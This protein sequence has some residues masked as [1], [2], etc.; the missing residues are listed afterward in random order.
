MTMPGPIDAEL[1]AQRRERHRRGQIE[2]DIGMLCLFGQLAASL[3]AG[4]WAVAEIEDS[5]GEL[6]VYAAV[7]FLFAL[8]AAHT[9]ANAA[10]FA[11]ALV[12]GTL[13]LPGL[14][15]RVTQSPPTPPLAESAADSRGEQ[16]FGAVVIFLHT[17]VFVLGVV[18]LAGLV[19]WTQEGT[20]FG[21]LVWRFV[22]PALLLSLLTPRALSVMWSG[23][24]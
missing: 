15:R 14:V 4:G 7:G 3:A 21:E 9:T 17:G 19:A 24:E 1:D 13:A 12:A 23:G 18:L 2:S 10:R 16:A 6:A 5:L 22:L 11:G 8:A 20:T